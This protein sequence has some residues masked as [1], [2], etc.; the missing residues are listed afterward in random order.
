MSAVAV[1]GASSSRISQTF[2][3]AT[4]ELGRLLATEGIDIVCG[5][6]R[7]GLMA[8]VTDGALSAGGHVTGVLPSFMAERGWDHTGLSERIIT[9]TMHERKSAMLSRADAVIALPGGI[10]TFDELFEAMTWRQLSL[11]SGPIVMLNTDD[12][13]R[14]LLDMLERVEQLGFMRRR[15]ERLYSVAT[16]PAEA[17]A[18]ILNR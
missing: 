3:A 4:H 14:P 8:A 6:G 10:G 11:W 17:V 2:I 5:G 7:G 16:E 12:Y 9:E 18:M 1:Y 15:D 13:Y